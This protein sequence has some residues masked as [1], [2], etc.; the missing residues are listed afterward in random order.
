M[1]TWGGVLPSRL[2]AVGVGVGQ[3]VEV[4]LRVLQQIAGKPL[5][6]LQLG[7]GGLLLLR[8]AAGQLV[9]KARGPLGRCRLVCAVLDRGLSLLFGRRYRLQGKGRRKSVFPRGG[10]P[11]LP[12]AV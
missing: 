2:H 3:L 11:P 9:L 1:G 12:G 6:R 8:I 10:A 7:A 4:V 5:S